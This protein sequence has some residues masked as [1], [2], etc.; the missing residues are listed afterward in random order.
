MGLLLSRHREVLD[1]PRAHRLS[2]HR[3]VQAQAEAP[4]LRVHLD[5]QEAL[6]GDPDLQN[7]A[8]EGN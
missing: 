1:T 5:L 6:V 4:G 8:A 3:E 2:R 7:Q